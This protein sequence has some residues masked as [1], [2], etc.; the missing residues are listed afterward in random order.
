MTKSSYIPQDWR[1][2]FGLTLTF[3]W[4][5]F[6]AIYISRNVGISNFMDLPIEEMGTFL[7][8]AFAFLAFLWLVIGLFIQQS[9][10][11]QNNEEL[12][13]N[14]L[15]SDKQ[16]QA[17]AAT[18]LNARQET[19]FKIAESTK[20]QLGGIAGMLFVSSQGPAGN[21]SYSTEVISEI[22]K[23]F[24][25][26]D[27]EVFSRLFLT[28]PQADTSFEELFFGTE[29]RKR[30]SDN[31][32]VG[33]DRLIELAKGCDT[34]KIIFDSLIY[35]AH[36]L[37]SN[38]LRELHPEVKFEMLEGTDSASYLERFAELEVDAE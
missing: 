4:F 36:G 14:N 31:F 3:V 33:F 7:E 22:W 21:E 26:G 12:R 6:L 18:E 37:L 19:F 5:V 13:L 11:A 24:A 16:T 28:M 35:S 17:I 34:D 23:Q 25:G 9:V 15:H 32:L 27:Y 10:L 1:I 8:G 30:H 38:R 20:R 2:L 29:I